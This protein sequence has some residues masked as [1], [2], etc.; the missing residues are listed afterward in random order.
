MNSSQLHVTLIALI[1]CKSYSGTHRCCEFMSVSSSCVQEMLFCFGSSW[2]LILFL[3]FLPSS[4]SD[5]LWALRKGGWAFNFHR[6]CFTFLLFT[7]GKFPWLCCAFISLLHWS[8][9]L[10]KK[11]TGDRIGTGREGKTMLYLHTLAI[12]ESWLKLCE[13]G[14]VKSFIFT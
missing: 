12:T 1:L 6:T 4:F 11:K 3:V 7:R 5:G 8:S 10:L 9:G 13:F 14:E 2:P